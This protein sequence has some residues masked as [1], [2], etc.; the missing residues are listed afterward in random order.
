MAGPSFLSGSRLSHPSPRARGQQRRGAATV[1]ANLF[2]R[3]ARIVKSYADAVVTA[4]EDPEKLLDQTVKEMQEDLIKMKQTSASV[5]A[6]QKSIQ[7]KYEQA[8]SA[9]DDWYRRADLALEKG[10]EELAREALKR[11][12]SYQES[13]DGLKK[14]LAYQAD[15]VQT[16]IANTRKLESKLAESKS[17]KD[18]LKARAQSAKASKAVN[19][20][21]GSLSTSTSAAAFDRMEE[22]VLQMEAESEAT[23]QLVIGDELEGKFVELEGG[24]VEDELRALKDKKLPG[25]TVRAQLPEGRPVKDALD[26][27]LD[28]L[29]RK[30]RD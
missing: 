13:A 5:I 24:S 23:Q 2:S 15:A 11:K 17:K 16:L 26:A 12:R 18:T 9:A 25:G 4:A 28:E 29:R 6:S 3:V 1:E 10:D 30:A 7:A 8:Q 27:E 19:E 22:R 21:V 14:Q 20:M